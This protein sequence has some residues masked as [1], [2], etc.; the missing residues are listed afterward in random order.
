MQHFMSI[1]LHLHA[2]VEKKPIHECTGFGV[3]IKLFRYL[4]STCDTSRTA[5]VSALVVMAA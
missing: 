2:K 1:I 4:R 3:S 5:P